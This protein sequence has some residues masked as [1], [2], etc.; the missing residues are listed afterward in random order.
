MEGSTES[1]YILVRDD[2]YYYD[3]KLFGNLD[4]VSKEAFETVLGDIEDTD[5][6][7]ESYKPENIFYF[8]LIDIDKTKIF[9]YKCNLKEKTYKLKENADIAKF[10]LQT[11]NMEQ[12]LDFFHKGF[13][14]NG[15]SLNGPYDFNYFIDRL[16]KD[17]LCE[18]AKFIPKKIDFS[19]GNYGKKNLI[20]FQNIVTKL[21]TK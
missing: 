9:E 21:S 8:K 16:T 12:L 13:D 1:K 3:Y 17:Q 5:Q 2:N 18:M 10:A 6:V 14:D 20:L 11:L 7:N 19:D 4:K 15:N